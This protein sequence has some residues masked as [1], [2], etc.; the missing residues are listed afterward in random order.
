[1]GGLEA[2]EGVVSLFSRCHC[3]Y[4][5]RVL[6]RP[7][8]KALGTLTRHWAFPPYVDADPLGPS[9]QQPGLSWFS[10]VS[11]LFA[12]CPTDP[13]RSAV[14]AAGEVGRRPGVP[15]AVEGEVP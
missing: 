2:I 1:M 5:R 3:V 12:E 14:V 8:V 6:A 13:G 11:R 10:G 15:V 4:L 9:S 7:R